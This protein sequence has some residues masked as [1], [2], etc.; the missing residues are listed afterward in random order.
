MMVCG[1]ELSLGQAWGWDTHCNARNW[2]SNHMRKD[3]SWDCEG[4]GFQQLNQCVNWT[5]IVRRGRQLGGSK[6]RSVELWDTQAPMRVEAAVGQCM[7][8]FTNT[9]S[10][11]WRRLLVLA[12]YNQTWPRDVPVPVEVTGTLSVPSVKKLK[13]LLIHVSAFPLP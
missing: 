10:P 3:V 13:S 8:L 1:E 11:P 9:A 12:R 7:W 5:E 6:S 4:S 2:G